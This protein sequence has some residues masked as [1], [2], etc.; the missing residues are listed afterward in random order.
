MF[1]DDSVTA[2][3]TISTVSD[4]ENSANIPVV[5]RWQKKKAQPGRNYA[6]GCSGSGWKRGSH[7]SAIVPAIVRRNSRR[8]LGEFTHVFS[9]LETLFRL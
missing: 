1:A 4:S 7:S 2:R 5:K 6:S 3:A 9:P 8:Y